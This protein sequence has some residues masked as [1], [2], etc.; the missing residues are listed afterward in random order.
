VIRLYLELD[1]EQ[2]EV[3]SFALHNGALNLPARAEP[4]GGESEGFTWE[5]FEDLFYQ[6]RPGEELRGEE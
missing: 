4:V 3:L 2:A 6:G 1:R 5:D